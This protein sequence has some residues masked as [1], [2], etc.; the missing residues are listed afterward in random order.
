MSCWSSLR[1]YEAKYVI[2]AEKDAYQVLD[3]HQ[4]NSFIMTGASG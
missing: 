2:T 3:S 1:L 4:L